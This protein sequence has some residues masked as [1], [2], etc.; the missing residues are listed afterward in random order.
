MRTLLRAWLSP[1]KEAPDTTNGT[2][3]V[4]HALIYARC[5]TL[6]YGRSTPPVGRAEVACLPRSGSA[7]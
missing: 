3:N 1:G 5:Q 7:V 6:G 4:H 2:P